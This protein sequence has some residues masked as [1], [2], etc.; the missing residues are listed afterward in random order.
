MLD[1]GAIEI[2]GEI[3]PGDDVDFGAKLLTLPR[4]RPIEVYL[5]SPGGS[6]LIGLKIA[7]LVHNAEL[8]TRVPYRGRCY[9]ACVLVFA[10][11]RERVANSK[12]TI[13]SLSR[14][15]GRGK[16]RW[17]AAGEFWNLGHDGPHGSRHG[18]V[19]R[20]SV[21]HRKNGR[22]TD[23]RDD[24]ADTGRSRSRGTLRSPGTCRVRTPIDRHRQSNLRHLL[25]K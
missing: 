16:R 20:P 10:A 19:R 6:V 12:A 3:V 15:T 7:S 25:R 1:G 11:G 2:D 22:N 17:R 18:R 24:G 4:D 9:S 21:G 23:R 5:N 13:G 8:I 14:I